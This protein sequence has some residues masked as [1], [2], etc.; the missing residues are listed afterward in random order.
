MAWNITFKMIDG[1]ARHIDWGAFLYSVWCH[2][3]SFL[4]TCHH[5]CSKSL[6]SIYW[7]HRKKNTPFYQSH[8]KYNGLLSSPSPR[9]SGTVALICGWSFFPW[10]MYI[11]VSKRRGFVEGK[12]MMNH[13]NWRVSQKYPNMWLY[14]GNQAHVSEV[15]LSPPWFFRC[16]LVSPVGVAPRLKAEVSAG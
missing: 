3:M 10:F 1:N 2:C 12:M 9:S 15:S 8:H 13:E 7:R 4:C 11:D 5:F 16:C 6:W 14:V